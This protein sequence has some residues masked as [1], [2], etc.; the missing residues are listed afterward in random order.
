MSSQAP[1]VGLQYSSWRCT[2]R[3]PLLALCTRRATT[4]DWLARLVSCSH[5]RSQVFQPLP[6]SHMR[7]HE[8]DS[9][10]SCRPPQMRSVDCTYLN[11]SHAS[12]TTDEL[13]NQPPRAN[14]DTHISRHGPFGLLTVSNQIAQASHAWMKP[15][16]RCSTSSATSVTSTCPRKRFSQVKTPVLIVFAPPRRTQASVA[17]GITDLQRLQYH[18]LSY[19]DC[20]FQIFVCSICSGT[21][22]LS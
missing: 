6:S 4:K 14:E 5:A 20:N 16:G 7:R 15:G 8:I 11:Q 17:T 19:S 1:D 12:P 2:N 22:V 13:A 21:R 9:S 18:R 3:E 10:Q